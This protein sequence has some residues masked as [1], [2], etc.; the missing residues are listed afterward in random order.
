VERLGGKKVIALDV[1]V[2]ATSNRVLKEEVA[3]GRF[4]E[5]LFYR[6]NVFPLHL[7][8]LRER[9]ADI[10]P[11]A[12]HLL[13]RHSQAA[14]RA[15]P[16]LSAAAQAMLEGHPWPGNVRELD[17]VM[18]RALILAAGGAVV[19]TDQLRFEVATAPV[20]GAVACAAEN[21]LGEDLRSRERRLILDALAAGK[22]SRKLAAARLGISPRTLRYKLARMR[23]AG[24]DVPGAAGQ[25]DQGCSHE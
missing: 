18:Q 7:P 24:I 19:D 17:N 21:V 20:S 25:I 8:A 11:L 12:R 10:V 13:V 22:G 4:R 3:A 14:G 2:I 5:D 15:V 9:R 1:R 6:L 16:E 23:D